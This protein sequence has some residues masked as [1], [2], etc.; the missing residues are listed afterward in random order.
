MCVCVCVCVCVLCARAFVRE[1]VCAG[2][3]SRALTTFARASVCAFVRS[4]VLSSRRGRSCRESSISADGGSAAAWQR[5]QS[6]AFSAAS[7]GRRNQ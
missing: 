4:R 1:R 5:A 7:C 3:C 2:L 6:R